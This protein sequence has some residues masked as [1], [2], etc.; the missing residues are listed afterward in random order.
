MQCDCCMDSKV[1]TSETNEEYLRILIEEY[2][3]RRNK[4]KK[5]SIRAFAKYLGVSHSMLSQIFLNQK[6]ISE[7][8]AEK[9]A[10]KL[11]LNTLEKSIFINST[12]KCFAR[13]NSEKVRASANLDKLMQSYAN[14]ALLKKEGIANI[15]HWSYV[16]IFETI[17][18]KKANTLDSIGTYL[19]L[20]AKNIEKVLNDLILLNIIQITDG[21]ILALSN[22]IQTTND[23]PTLA[24]KDYHVSMT[25]KMA[26]A[27]ENHSVNDREFQ[28]TVLSF[29][30]D[31]MTAAKKMIR[32]FII[33]FNT[34]FHLDNPTPPLYSLSVGFFKL[35]KD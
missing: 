19:N 6:G 35:N 15:N 17:C 3:V 16:A 33:E 22:S 12:V 25:A 30:A 10:D 23:I 4:N 18:M 7:Q 9:I 26:E 28:N 11:H 29:P 31:Q 2:R 8:M 24:I 5:Y 20:P 21:H 14:N 13:S 1:L 32:D 34:Q 27:L